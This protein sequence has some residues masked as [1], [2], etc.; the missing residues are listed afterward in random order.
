MHAHAHAHAHTHTHTYTNIYL[1]TYLPTYVP[2]C[3]HKTHTVYVYVHIYMYIYIHIHRY[4]RIISSNLVAYIYLFTYSYLAIYLLIDC[5]LAT[6]MTRTIR[7][8]NVWTCFVCPSKSTDVISTCASRSRS[9]W[10][11]E[12]RNQTKRM[13]SSRN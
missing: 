4:I 13:G 1:P 8:S 2:I 10:R 12:L 3:I 5:V 6:N 7:P 11:N 9:D